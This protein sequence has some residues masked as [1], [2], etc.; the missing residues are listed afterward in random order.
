MDPNDAA[1]LKALIWI[2]I[3]AGSVLLR[4]CARTEQELVEH[5]G[6]QLDE[7]TGADASYTCAPT[8]KEKILVGV[9]KQ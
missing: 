1:A 8:G 5:L 6:R 4:W 9:R 3:F 2:A 7:E